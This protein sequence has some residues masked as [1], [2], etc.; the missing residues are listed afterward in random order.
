MSNNSDPRTQQLVA[1]RDQAESAFRAAANS[2]TF[3]SVCEQLRSAG[4]EHSAATSAARDAEEEVLRV[5]T[6]V[7]ATPRT[8]KVR[9]TGS[10]LDRAR[11]VSIGIPTL[12]DLRQVIMFDPRNISAPEPT[13]HQAAAEAAASAEAR[14]RNKFF[15]A[16]DRYTE[17][18]EHIL[19][20]GRQYHQARL[21]CEQAEGRIT[22]DG[23]DTDALALNDFSSLPHV[24]G[25]DEYMDI[26]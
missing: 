21:Q 19:T 4:A 12:D 6:S 18:K 16:L 22:I 1:A 2:Q 13:E 15:I 17:Q 7:P 5:D 8:G 24:Q 25:L 23:G 3:I 11:R 26:R 14:A 20:L 10:L 9:D